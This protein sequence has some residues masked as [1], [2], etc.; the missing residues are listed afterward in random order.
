MKNYKKNIK[1]KPHEKTLSSAD[2]NPKPFMG[3]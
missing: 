3:Y 1:I 2:F